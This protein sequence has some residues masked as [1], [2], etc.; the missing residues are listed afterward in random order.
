MRESSRISALRAA[1][2][3]ATRWSSGLGSEGSERLRLYRMSREQ[4]VPHRLGS[5]RSEQRLSRPAEH[6]PSAGQ[7]LMSRISP[8]R[9][10]TF[11][12]PQVVVARARLVVSDLIAPSSDLHTGR[13]ATVALA[14]CCL[15]SHRPEWRVSPALYAVAGAPRTHDV[16]DL[17]APSSDFFTIRQ[18][19]MAVCPAAVSDLSAP[20]SNLRSRHSRL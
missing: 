10:A 2:C 4:L 11:T 3:L 1:I 15:G 17:S 20:S 9:A 19:I 12:R 8:P 6:Q 5:H 16:S 13:T 18:P 14:A 7:I